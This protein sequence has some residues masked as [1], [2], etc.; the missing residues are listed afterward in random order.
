M[1]M[2]RN[3]RLNRGKTILRKKMG[4]MKRTRFKGN[5]T[6][7]KTIGMVWDASNPEDLTYLSQFYQKMAEKNIEV[8]IIGY[9]PGKDLPDRLTAIRYL[10]CLKK[11]DINITYRPVSDEANSFIM[12][13][14]DILIDINFKDIFPLRYISYLSMAG[15]K[16]GIFDNRSA[17]SP[18]DLMMEFNKTTDI[19]SYLTQVVHYLEMINSGQSQKGE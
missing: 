7:A 16:V 13:R 10:T 18:F 9:Y 1:E 17:N 3:I 6:N 4:R 8:K 12:T 2:F 5:I 11:E 15:L 19:N 14:F